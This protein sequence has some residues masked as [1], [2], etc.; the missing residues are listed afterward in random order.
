MSTYT[1]FCRDGK[2]P[3][4]TIWISTVEAD[5]ALQARKVGR[6]ECADDW[7][8]TERES[9]DSCGDIEDIQVLGVVEGTIN[10]LDWDDDGL[11]IPA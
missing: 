8:Y 11:E 4:S 2:D 10:L 9:E 7:D 1:V 5:N 6:N 3:G